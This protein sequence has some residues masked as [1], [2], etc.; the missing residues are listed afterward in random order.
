MYKKIMSGLILCTLLVSLLLPLPKGFA[1]GSTGVLQ[2][3]DDFSAGMSLWNGI[4]GSWVVDNGALRV[5]SS[6]SNNIEM[7]GTN[8]V[9]QDQIVD[10]RLK[11]LETPGGGFTR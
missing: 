3:Q 6:S 5:T 7:K 8:S 9:W 11:I 1:A 4:N 2:F 10:F